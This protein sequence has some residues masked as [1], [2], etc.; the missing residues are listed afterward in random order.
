[1]NSFSRQLLN[2]KADGGRRWHLFGS[3]LRYLLLNPQAPGRA[4]EVGERHYDI[5]N[6]VFEAML[7]PTMSYSCGY[8]ADAD[9]LVDAQ[10]HKLELICRKLEL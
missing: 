6:D 3:A 4:F 5:G 7:D 9:N 8:W 1:M 2:E 10:R